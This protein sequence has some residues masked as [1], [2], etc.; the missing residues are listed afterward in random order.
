MRLRFALLLIILTA[1]QHFGAAA[2]SSVPSQP[3]NPGHFRNP[4][5]P[6]PDPWLLWHSG[7]Y[8]LATTQ[9][10]CIRMWKAPSL[11]KLKT[12]AP[13]VVWRD[14]D[15]TRS[16][17]IWAPEF[18]FIS[19]RW[20]LYYTA[21]AA[22]KVDTTH[23]LYALE[24]EGTDPMGPYH[25]KAR[26]FDPAN[27]FYA[28]D[29]S[30]FQHP[31]D[32]RWYFLW[33][34]HPGHRIRI[35]RM[36][37]PWTFEGRSVEIPAS[38]FGC[39]EVREG[40]VVLQRN[41]KLFLTYSACDTG[42]PDYKLGMLIADDRADVLNPKS[43]VQ[44]PTPLLERNDSA[45]VFGPGHHGFFKSPDSKEDWIVFH[46]KTT[47]AYTYAGRTTRAQPITWSANGLPDL[48]SP[49]PLTAQI[50]EPS[51]TQ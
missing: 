51:G 41:S 7:N 39:E 22:T 23:R 1:A 45:G 16:H 25:F 31:G 24:S 18:N 49:L 20:Y 43:W 11:A 37:N 2:E 50:P 47:S 19:N 36:S 48:A 34:A 17:G 8:Y 33:A 40:P 9:G 38:G 10:D 12:S 13:T 27:D 35:A 44:H 29:G 42:K 30:A 5:N 26:L 21:M 3:T 28:I 32:K 14:A 46:A 6:G 15:P 4:I